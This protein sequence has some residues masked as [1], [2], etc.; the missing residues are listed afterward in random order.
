MVKTYGVFNNWINP[1]LKVSDVNYGKGIFSTETIVAKERLAIFG[2]D[3]MLID[4]IKN[5]P[6]HLQEY[7]L[8]IEERFLIYGKKNTEPESTDFFN[9]SCEPNAGIKGQLF[10]V[11]MR[12]I[13]AGE[14]ITFDYAMVVSASVGSDI[15]FKMQC[16]C[17]TKNCR[18]TITE[19]DWQLPALRKKYQGYFSQYLQERIEIEEA[20]NMT[21]AI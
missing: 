12:D 19:Y 15:V 9:H 21:S 4:E 6:L 8:Q 13:K 11:A 18:K 5:L 16:R 1:K 20:E 10:L 3:I 14:E 2:G 7:P 17:E